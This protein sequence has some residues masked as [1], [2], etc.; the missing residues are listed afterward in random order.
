MTRSRPPEL[1]LPVAGYLLSFLVVGLSLSI[2]GPALSELRERSGTDLGGIGVLFVGQ[3]CGYVLGS[4]LSGSLYDRFDG[5][6]V[7]GLALVA[8]AGGLVV[9][10]SLA[11][12]PALFAIFV[13]IGLGAATVDVGANTLLIWEL[14]ARVGRAMNLLH[15]CFGIGALTAPLAVHA[16]LGIAAY[17]AAAL[18][19]ALA[20]MIIPSRS[21]VASTERHEE[22]TDTNRPMLALLATFFLLYVGLEIGFAGWITTYG[23]E[24]SFSDLEATWLTVTFW[25]G[26]TLGR[27]LSSIIVQRVRPKLLLGGSCV[28]TIVV[29]AALI[30]GDG[31]PVTVWI[32]AGAMGLATAPQFP[33]MFTYLERRIRVTGNATAWFVGAAGMGGLVFPW[34]IGQW[35]DASGPGVLP[36]SM[37]LLGV[38]TLTSFAVSNRVLGG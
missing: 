14:G 18:C 21:P 33:M 1:G 17:L 15:L 23:R 28:L 5:H 16:G 20:A 37:L 8:M 10:P 30:V 2:L 22:H 32:G 36:W 38:A 9:L 25:V 27:L 11:T 29:A 19:L 24:I 26:F 35:F 34:V 3:S 31:R 4:F 6:R 13:V 12:L 7:Y